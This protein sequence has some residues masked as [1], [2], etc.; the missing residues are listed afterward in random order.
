MTSGDYDSE[1]CS[2]SASRQTT[3][4]ATRLMSPTSFPFRRLQGRTVRKTRWTRRSCCKH[5]GEGGAHG[6][7]GAVVRRSGRRMFWRGQ[8]RRQKQK[9][10]HL[11]QLRRTLLPRSRSECAGTHTGAT[12]IW[13]LPPLRPKEDGWNIGMLTTHHRTQLPP[14]IECRLS[15]FLR[16]DGAGGALP[17]SSAEPDFSAYAPRATS[18]PSAAAVLAW[19]PFLCTRS[20]RSPIAAK[21]GTLTTKPKSTRVMSPRLP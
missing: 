6:W 8:L 10:Q 18:P 16:A 12:P 15:V 4:T 3:A 14:G 21:G 5:G 19:P 2:S 13:L 9:Q 17:R 7:R 20:T 1:L 11:L